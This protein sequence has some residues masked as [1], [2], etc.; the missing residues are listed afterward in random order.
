MKPS[1]AYRFASDEEAMGLFNDA[2]QAVF[3][4]FSKTSPD[5][6][7]AL[8]RLRMKLECLDDLKGKI[9]SLAHDFARGQK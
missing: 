4:E 2:R 6:P 5:D 3:E 9:T 7:G 1:A 8:V